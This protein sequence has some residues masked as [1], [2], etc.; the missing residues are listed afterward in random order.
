MK[1]RTAPDMPN[2][3][4]ACY[5]CGAEIIGPIQSGPNY[6]ADDGPRAYHPACYDLAELLASIDLSNNGYIFAPAPGQLK[7]AS[8]NPATV[9]IA[10]T[11]SADFPYRITRKVAP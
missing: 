11:A 3:A 9:S 8:A 7:T 6:H 4:R 5:Q 1:K 10:C 2:H